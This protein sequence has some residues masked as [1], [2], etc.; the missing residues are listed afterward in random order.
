MQPGGFKIKRVGEDLPKES[1]DSVNPDT[2]EANANENQ[3]TTSKPNRLRLA[4]KKSNVEPAKS[5][6]I[7]SNGK[8]CPECNSPVQENAVLCVSCGYNFKK[9]KKVKTK[10]NLDNKPPSFP[11][12]KTA[13]NVKAKKPGGSFF[14]KLI[15]FCIFIGILA[16]AG[17]YFLIKPAMD[18][19][20]VARE[21][22]ICKSQ[23]RRLVS[24][25]PEEV[26]DSVRCPT[27]NNV[28]EFYWPSNG[29]NPLKVL[30]AF[31]SHF[32]LS[33]NVGSQQIYLLRV[34]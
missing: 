23:L 32:A 7:K 26:N 13:G 22:A 30:K 3:S 2:E 17:Y 21:R 25:F 4:N 33:M 19:Q 29:Q 14:F 31:S 8:V 11:R 20:N 28:Y 16:G 1:D 12:R 5:E 24:M 18:E 9:G 10:C 15:K 34:K 6:E 27:C